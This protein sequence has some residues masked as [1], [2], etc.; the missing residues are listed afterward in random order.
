MSSNI[1]EI[2]P[3]EILEH[4]VKYLK[5]QQLKNVKLTCKTWMECVLQ[6]ERKEN[7]KSK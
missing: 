4:I 7:M 2:L 3:I 5:L 1:N 6:R